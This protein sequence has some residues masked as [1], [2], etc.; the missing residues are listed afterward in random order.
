MNEVFTI[1][2]E[3]EQRAGE[4][5]RLQ[6]PPA[7]SRTAAAAKRCRHGSAVARGMER[8]AQSS[9]QRAETATAIDPLAGCGSIGGAAL[10]IWFRVGQHVEGWIWW[11]AA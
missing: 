4:H 11:H 10:G 1:H 9:G 2:H 5:R 6:F 3:G 7:L 8:G